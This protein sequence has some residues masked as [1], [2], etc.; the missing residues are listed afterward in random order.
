MSSKR[1]FEKFPLMTNT[2][3]IFCQI[4]S[5]IPLVSL[6]ESCQNKIVVANMWNKKQQW[7]TR[8]ENHCCVEYSDNV[9]VFSTHIQKT[10]FAV[11]KINPTVQTVSW[12]FCSLEQTDQI[13][14]ERFRHEKVFILRCCNLL[15][16]GHL[17]RSQ[18]LPLSI[19]CYILCYFC[20]I[21]FYE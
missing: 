11:M 7:R 12:L 13:K 19:F 14:W 1:I 18:Y 2:K 3:L 15:N 6:R 5:S 9:A 8:S 4:C 20:G 16:V 10:S 17:I 21:H